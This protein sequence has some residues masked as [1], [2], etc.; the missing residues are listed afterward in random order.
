MTRRGSEER[1]H[2]RCRRTRRRPRGLCRQRPLMLRPVDE[3]GRLPL[4]EITRPPHLPRSHR[5][6]TTASGSSFWP[7]GPTWM[8]VPTSGQ[9]ETRR[10]EFSS[11]RSS[12][13]PRSV[14]SRRK[15]AVPSSAAERWSP[16]P[17]S[18]HRRQSGRSA[19]L[20]NSGTRRTEVE[21]APRAHRGRFGLTDRCG[22]RHG[23]REP[24]NLVGRHGDVAGLSRLTPRTGH[25]GHHVRL[26]PLTSTPPFWPKRLDPLSHEAT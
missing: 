2:S 3:I 18:W 24:G 12:A 9:T 10:Q 22:R 19:R 6:H 8:S 1:A 20:R 13:Q 7:V 5:P 23:D 4:H 11:S 16:C 25:L 21:P 14:H 17:K 15:G 26:C